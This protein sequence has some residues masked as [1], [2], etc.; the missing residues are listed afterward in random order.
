VDQDSRVGDVRKNFDEEVVAHEIGV[1]VECPTAF[2]ACF[3]DQLEVASEV[4]NQ[5]RTQ[6]KTGEGHKD[7]LADR[8]FK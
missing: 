3:E 5:K 7:L 1:F 6:E 8:R 2:F 4:A